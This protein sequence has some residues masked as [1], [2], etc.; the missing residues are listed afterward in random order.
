MMIWNALFVENSILMKE[1][2][3]IF[4]LFVVGLMMIFKST[5]PICLVVI[6]DHSMN[7]VNSGKTVLFLITSMTLSNRIKTDYRLSN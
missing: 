3:M 5:I 4:A 2:I 1:T 6:T 7:T